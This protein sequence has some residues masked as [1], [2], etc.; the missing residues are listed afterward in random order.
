MNG[1]NVWIH[2]AEDIHQLLLDSCTSWLTH[3]P[4]EPQ[5]CLFAMLSGCHL[6]DVIRLALQQL[7]CTPPAGDL[8]TLKQAVSPAY[9]GMPV[10]PELI[11]LIDQ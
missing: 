9:A 6:K 7:P 11:K 3:G 1:N 10:G 2:F 4:S 8:L 5:D